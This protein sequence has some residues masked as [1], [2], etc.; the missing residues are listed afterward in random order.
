MSETNKNLIA[1]LLAAVIVFILSPILCYFGGWI[2]GWLTKVTIGSWFVTTV[3]SMLGTTITA[4]ML[5]TLG[6]ILGVITHSFR[7]NIGSK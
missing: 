3:N 5:P 6:G 7:L 1:V 2:F 4:E